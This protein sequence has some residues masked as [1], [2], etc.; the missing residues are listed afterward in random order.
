MCLIALRGQSVDLYTRSFSSAAANTYLSVASTTYSAALIDELKC[1][2]I[3]KIKAS[4]YEIDLVLF[5]LNNPFTIQLE[6]TRNCDYRVVKATLIDF[7]SNDDA[8]IVFSQ[9]SIEG[10]LSTILDL[11]SKS[12][13]FTWKK[14]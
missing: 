9:S 7:G 3:S 2:E 14:N 11:T 4:I 5:P 8:V 10:P 6:V 13:N 12:I 1:S